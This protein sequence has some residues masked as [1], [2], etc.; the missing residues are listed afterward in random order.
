MDIKKMS[1]EEEEFLYDA[2]DEY[3]ETG[4]ITRVCPRCGGKLAYIG[5]NS[6]Y[7]IICEDNCGVLLSIRGL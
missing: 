1:E 6:S 3:Q 2:A 5:N 7:R 4:V